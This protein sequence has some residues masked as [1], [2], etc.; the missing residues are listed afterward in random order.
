MR[1][2]IHRIAVVCVIGVFV[3]VLGSSAF[4]AQPHTR[5]SEARVLWKAS[6][7]H[8]SL[9]QPVISGDTIFVGSC[10]G[11]FYALDK[12]TGKVEWSH[13]THADGATGSFEISPLLS[14]GLVIAGTTGSCSVND[15][16]YVYA[17]DP[18]AG[19]V[20][21]KLQVGAASSSFANL[22]EA[23]PKGSVVFGT[24]NGE[25]VSAEATTGKVNWRFRATPADTNCHSKMS[26]VTDGVQVCLLIQNGN[27]HC[28]DGKSGRELWKRK[29]D[30]EPNTDVLMYKDV[31][32]FGSADKHIYGL[33]PETGKNL[34]QLQTPY[35]LVGAIA[36]TAREEDGEYEFAYAMN[37]SAGNAAVMSFSDEFSRVRW[38]RTSSER[39]SSNQPEPWGKVVIAGSC[40]GDVLALSVK[41]GEPQWHAH[42]DGCIQ[43]FAH[44]DSTLYISVGEGAIY[45]Y[46]PPQSK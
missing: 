31:L 45:A 44:D 40:R 6:P 46:G 39:W 5:T 19:A 29:P 11:K 30:S 32:Y 22:D 28:L 26:V 13:E 43:S 9:T 17:F 8:C 33:D 35:A 37:G 20:R 42:V 41:D 7:A 10:D 21:W 25:W 24:R 12:E 14:H 38:S 4:S 1:N 36:K 15:G 27:L 2:R 16:G 34:V 18:K 3:L 23:D